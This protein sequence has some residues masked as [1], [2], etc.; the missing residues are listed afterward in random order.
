MCPF[1]SRR[2]FFHFL[3]LVVLLFHHGGCPFCL[4]LQICANKSIIINRLPLIVSQWRSTGCH[5]SLV[6]RGQK[7]K[8]WLSTF[9]Y[10]HEVPAILSD[11]GPVACRMWHYLSCLLVLPTQLSTYRPVILLST[12]EGRVFLAES[13]SS[14][15]AKV[16]NHHTC[17][18]E[19]R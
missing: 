8:V 16:L 18:Y 17:V 15:S 9:I 12:V 3:A 4:L 11:A 19:I 1:I 14:H 10:F 7:T 13:P 2:P 6:R 5:L